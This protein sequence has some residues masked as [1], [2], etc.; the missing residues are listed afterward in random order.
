MDADELADLLPPLPRGRDLPHLAAHRAALLAVLPSPARVR[1]ERRGIRARRILVPLAAAAA[2]LAVVLVVVTLPLHQVGEDRTTSGSLGRS[3]RPAFHGS[4][5]LAAPRRW[6]VALTGVTSVAVH[7]NSGTVSVAAQL[8]SA[9]LVS[10]SGVIS[11]GSASVTATPAYHGTAPVVSTTVRGHT[12]TIDARCLPGSG[13]SCHVSLTVSLPRSMPV[14]ASS[15]LGDVTILGLSGPVAVRD[16]LGDIGL[17]DLTG[18][19]T[20][21]DDLGDISGWGLTG[22]RARLADNLGTIDVSFAMPPASIDATNQGGDIALSVPSWA[23]YH[24]TAHSQLGSVSVTVPH[25][26]SG[27]SAHLITATSQ[28]GDVTVSS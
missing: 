13:R 5:A 2:V 19:V 28:L 20:A 22:S 16:D 24:V 10:P 14:T 18:P 8:A 4:G 9:E 7:T 26:V 3:T 27:S 17:D 21:T 12:L 6:Q 23:S 25:Q 15:Q 11:L 1:P